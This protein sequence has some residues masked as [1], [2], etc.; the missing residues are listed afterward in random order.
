LSTCA[1]RRYQTGASVVSI[2]VI[3]ACRAHLMASQ[4][5]AAQPQPSSNLPNKDT[6]ARPSPPRLLSTLRGKRP[7]ALERDSTCVRTH[8]TTSQ[9]YRC[10]ARGWQLGVHVDTE[11]RV[12][13]RTEYHTAGGLL[14]RRQTSPAQS[15]MDCPPRSESLAAGSDQTMVY[16]GIRQRHT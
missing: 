6:H 15:T 11:P 9:P 5:R 3:C 10:N 4:Y 1:A 8:L 7:P 2:Y 13:Y 12:T 14:G 16:R